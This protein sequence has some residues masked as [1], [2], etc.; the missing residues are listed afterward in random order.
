MDR[1]NRKTKTGVVVSNKMQKTVVVEI[2]QVFSH[3]FF[4]KTMRSYQRFKAHD[5]ENK[6][7]VGNLVE[8]METRPLARDKRW[9]VVRI[10]GQ[11]TVRA[12]DLPKHRVVKAKEAE[13]AVEG[14]EN[15]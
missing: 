2:E 9:R 6:C 13:K 3:P 7:A 8:I 10:I 12:K 11:G 1:K 4:G 14:G 15:Q 5:A